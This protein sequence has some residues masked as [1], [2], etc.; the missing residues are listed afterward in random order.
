MFVGRLVNAK[1]LDWHYY[2]LALRMSHP[3]L[4][5][6]LWYSGTLAGSVSV[7]FD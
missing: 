3:C 1:A 5:A 4:F 2:S 7:P 6:Q